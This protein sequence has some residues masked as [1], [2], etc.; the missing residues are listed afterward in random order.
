MHAIR[1]EPEVRWRWLAITLSLYKSFVITTARATGLREISTTVSALD[2]NRPGS[3]VVLRGR[4]GSMAR[5]RSRGKARERLRPCRRLGIKHSHPQRLIYRRR[6]NHGAEEGEQGRAVDETGAG[7]GL[8]LADGSHEHPGGCPADPE[9]ML[10]ATLLQVSV[11]EREVF[12][13]RGTT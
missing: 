6:F 12:A 9:Q 11:G 8:H 2:S 5:R 4:S 7:G 3:K 10:Q 1:L 13:I